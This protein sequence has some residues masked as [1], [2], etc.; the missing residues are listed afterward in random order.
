MGRSVDASNQSCLLSRSGFWTQKRI[1][2]VRFL[3][4][5]HRGGPLSGFL[6]LSGLH[7]FIHSFIHGDGDTGHQFEPQMPINWDAH[8]PGLAT[9][10]FPQSTKTP[11]ESV[12][13]APRSHAL[14]TTRTHAQGKEAMRSLLLTVFSLEVWNKLL[15]IVGNLS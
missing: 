5:R 9:V 7:S 8:R 1:Y 11:Q 10:G 4:S 14:T 3:A 2:P 6:P 13:K 12:K 15:I